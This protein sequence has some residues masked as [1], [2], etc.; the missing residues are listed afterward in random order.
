M[1]IRGPE[2]LAG[3]EGLDFVETLGYEL[4]RDLEIR[5]GSLGW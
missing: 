4:E 3:W 1:W 2:V 5:V